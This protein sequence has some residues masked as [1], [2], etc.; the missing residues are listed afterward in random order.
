VSTGRKCEGF[1][2]DVAVK[3]PVAF[4]PPT[5]LL[6][7][8]LDEKEAQHLNNFRHLFVPG[9]SGYANSPRWEKLILQA[10]HEEPAVR[11]AAIAFSALQL[12]SCND[13]LPLSSKR[14]EMFALQQYGKSV[15][16]F[17]QLLSRQDRRSTKAALLC[18]ILCI[19][20]EV[21]EG[22]HLVAQQHLENGLRVLSSVEGTLIRHYTVT[23]L[24]RFSAIVDEDLSRAFARLDVQA[25]SYVGRRTPS[26]ALPIVHR[27]TTI[28]ISMDDAEKYLFQ[29]LSHIWAFLRGTAD[30]YRYREPD[31]IPIEVF[32]QAQLIDRRLSQWKKAFE[33]F[34]SVFHTKLLAA[35]VQ[36]VKLLQIHHH[37]ATILMA[38]SLHPEETIFDAFDDTFKS[39]VRLAEELFGNDFASPAAKTFSMEMGIIQ[40]LYITALKCRI[41]HVREKAI[42]L[43]L[44]VPNREGVW[45]SLV[46][47]NIA[48]RIR[49]IEEEGL[50]RSFLEI[51]RVPEFRRVHAADIDIDQKARRSGVSCRLRP[52][53]MDGEWDDREGFVTW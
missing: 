3:P 14:L 18:S 13:K 36:H 38:G 45:N 31:S 44:A 29:E 34:L 12:P 16:A 46:L 7:N 4:A 51:Y 21:L 22:S 26:V 39:I 49:E 27:Y 32:A 35:E 6:A 19:C 2:D 28:F 37:T 17:Q 47:V 30:E 8:F 1:V 25:S 23:Q 20:F 10:V 9:F 41:T 15:K 50:E 24:T 53:G 42:S 40:P 52:N 5:T 43:L 48:E 11:H 33:T